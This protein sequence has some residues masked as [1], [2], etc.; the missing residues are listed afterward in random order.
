MNELNPVTT[1]MDGGDNAGWHD[2][3][4]EI[5]TYAVVAV[6][7]LAGVLLA[8]MAATVTLPPVLLHPWQ[9]AAALSVAAGVGFFGG[10]L[11]MALAAA[12]SYSEQE[13]GE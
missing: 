3:Q 5:D 9:I 7:V 4:H 1:G 2:E 6:A 11:T 13:A 10:V 8:V 12:A